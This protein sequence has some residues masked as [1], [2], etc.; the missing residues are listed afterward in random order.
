MGKNLQRKRKPQTVSTNR[1]FIAIFEPRLKRAPGLNEEYEIITGRD[2]T[3]RYKYIQPGKLSR[4]KRKTV[5]L[6][7]LQE[8]KLRDEACKT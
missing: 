7:S 5:R 3:K 2:A 1:Y 8:R 6:V 4:R